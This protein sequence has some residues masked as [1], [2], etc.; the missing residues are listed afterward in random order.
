VSVNQRTLSPWARRPDVRIGAVIAVAA[1]VALVVWLLVRG[2]G[3][4]SSGQ[5]SAE[6]IAPKAASPTEIRDLSVETGRPI[7]W[8]G[9]E[10]DKVYE[11]Q[12]T[13]QDR[14]Y[15]RYLP[16]DVSVGTKSAGY[17]LVGTYPVHSAYS[18]LKS[19]AKVGGEVSFTAPRGAIAVY[20]QSR[21]TNIYLAYP[22]SDV[23]IEVYDPSPA[24]AR[25]LVASGRVVPVGS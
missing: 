25:S 1:L 18:V 14:V 8:L 4:D 9:P 3:S 21:P 5:P 17:R 6:P 22:G 10:D 2:G 20:S 12:R 19:L 7:Y 23:Q 13:S 16:P 24:Q 11:L 15:V